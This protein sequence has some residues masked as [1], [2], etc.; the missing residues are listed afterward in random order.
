MSQSN[1]MRPPS[2]WWA[3]NIRRSRS[4]LEVFGQRPASL[5]GAACRKIQFD[6]LPTT[7]FL[8]VELAD[9]PE[10]PPA[11]WLSNGCDTV[12]LKIEM[13]DCRDLSGSGAVEPCSINITPVGEKSNVMLFGPNFNFGFTAKYP[14]ICL[15][16]AIKS[17][18]VQ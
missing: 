6:A 8:H 3:K 9:F 4:L 2:D 18:G 1:E 7:V 12:A 16:R 15:M 14:L 13:S 11:R 17:Q 10:V 5:E